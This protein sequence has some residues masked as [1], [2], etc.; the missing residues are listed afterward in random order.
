[1]DISAFNLHNMNMARMSASNS[2]H[3]P[4]SS[5]LPGIGMNNTEQLRNP[6]MNPM[7]DFHQM[8][9][10]ALEA[11]RQTTAETSTESQTPIFSGG[12]AVI[13]RT[14]Q[15]FEACQELET[16]LIKTLISS[17]R[18]TIQKSELIDTG[19]AGQFYEDMLYD[20]YA[21]S[22]S[23]NAGFGFAEMAYLELTG[24]RGKTLTRRP[25][26]A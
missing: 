6:A 17:M 24:Q 14:S 13:D 21:K 8:L 18:N 23:M 22:F 26:F 3:I 2:G 5:Q 11:D 10:R 7:P 15:L 12:R 9:D 19:L 16:F 25:D 1:M 20:E 4:F